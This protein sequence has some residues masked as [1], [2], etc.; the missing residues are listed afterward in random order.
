MTSATRAPRA[1]ARRAAR[2]AVG[3]RRRIGRSF[4]SISATTRST[5]CSSAARSPAFVIT[6]VAAASLAASGSLRGDPRARVVG[7]EAVARDH[8]RAPGPRAV[9]ARRSARRARCARGSRRAARPRRTRPRAPASEPAAIARALAAAIRGCV[10]RPRSARACRIGERDRAEPL[11]IELAVGGRGSRRRTA[12]P[13]RRAPAGRARR[14]RARAGRRR[15]RRAALAEQPAT[16]LLPDAMPPVNPITCS[17]HAACV[18]TRQRRG[19]L[20]DARVAPALAR[21]RCRA[22]AAPPRA[23]G[24][25]APR[26][27]RVTRGARRVAGD[28]ARDAR[29]RGFD[30]GRRRGASPVTA[31]ARRRRGRR[32]RS[33]SAARPA[34]APARRTR[35]TT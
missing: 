28:T 1:V 12:R 15:R 21:A 7:R 24:P 11:A 35:P 8:A 32:S 17:R 2:G 18:T 19:R 33:R 9:P 29:A 14:P 23:T 16:V 22:S 6:Q 3:R 13:A 25:A 30:A 34:T 31:P 5:W 10:M 4:A 20:P 26:A 27:G